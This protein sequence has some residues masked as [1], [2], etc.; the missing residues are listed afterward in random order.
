[1]PNGFNRRIFDG[2]VI[3]VVLLAITINL[4]KAAGLRW[5]HQHEQGSITQQIGTALS[6]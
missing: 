5:K 6:A 2:T 4:A 3:T 1:M